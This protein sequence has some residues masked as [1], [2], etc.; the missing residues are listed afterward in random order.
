MNSWLEVFSR[1]QWFTDGT[2]L[3]LTERSDGL[4]CLAVEPMQFSEIHYLFTEVLDCA[5]VVV[6][7]YGGPAFFSGQVKEKFVQELADERSFL[8]VVV[9]NEETDATAFQEAMKQWPDHP[10]LAPGFRFQIHHGRRAAV[11]APLET[12]E[13]VLPYFFRRAFFETAEKNSR[14]DGMFR[15]DV[16]AAVRKGIRFRHP[17]RENDQ[18][19]FPE[20]TA[21]TGGI[22][23]RPEVSEILRKAL[24]EPVPGFRF[25]SDAQGNLRKTEDCMLDGGQLIREEWLYQGVL[26]WLCRA[27]LV[28]GLITLVAGFATGGILQIACWILAALSGLALVFTGESR[29]R[30]KQ[31]TGRVRVQIAELPEVERGNRPLQITLENCGRADLFNLY[32]RIAD[33]LD[34]KTGS[35]GYLASLP[36]GEKAL[37]TVILPPGKR[38]NTEWAK[39]LLVA[40]GT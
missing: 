18:D 30:R 22:L 27:A 8:E 10:L 31:A 29:R 13:S 23:A 3:R 2:T 20:V 35:D 24:P 6:T 37:L 9:V 34:L 12:L 26:P 14:S 25:V 11:I 16:S 28:S 39:D 32:L 36:V 40:D 1:N 19:T 21:M 4:A 15:R 17:R 33:K 5:H 7:G 38:E